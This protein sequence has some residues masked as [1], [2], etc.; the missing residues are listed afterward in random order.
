MRERGQVRN[1]KTNHWPTVARQF[2]KLVFWGLGSHRVWD[3]PIA[4]SIASAMKSNRLFLER[5]SLRIARTQPAP[6]TGAICT[7]SAAKSS[8]CLFGFLLGFKEYIEFHI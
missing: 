4:I 8:G 6:A 7:T 1:D 3:A 5:Y 2:P